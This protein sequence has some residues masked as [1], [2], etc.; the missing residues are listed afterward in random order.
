MC[1][2]CA[3]VFP[4]HYLSFH[5]PQTALKSRYHPQFSS[6]G[7]NSEFSNNLLRITQLVRG[8]INFQAQSNTGSFSHPVLRKQK[9]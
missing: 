7:S 3:K 9:K 6:W 5:P 8:R 4:L 1:R 2:H